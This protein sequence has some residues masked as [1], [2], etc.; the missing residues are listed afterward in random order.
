VNNTYFKS[1]FNLLGNIKEVTQYERSK[2][3]DEDS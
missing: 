3:Q 2:Q 1:V